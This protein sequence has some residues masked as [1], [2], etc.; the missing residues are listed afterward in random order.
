MRDRFDIGNLLSC[1]LLRNLE[2]QRLAI[3]YG[4]ETASSEYVKIL[5]KLLARHTD[6]RKPDCESLAE[7]LL[8]GRESCD[9]PLAKAKD[10]YDATSLRST[11]DSF[12]AYTT[13]EEI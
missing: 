1:H 10:R 11:L 3:I 13:V 4:F 7:R 9:I 5:A 2:P 6:L 8:R 12:G